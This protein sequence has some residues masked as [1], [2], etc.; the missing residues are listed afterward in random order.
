MYA[1]WLAN[2]SKLLGSYNFLLLAFPGILSWWAALSISHGRLPS[3]TTSKGCLIFN[4][5]VGGD[6]ELD[7]TTI[8]S[9]RSL[10]ALFARK[11]Q[12]RDTA[13]WDNISARYGSNPDVVVIP[14]CKNYV[15]VTHASGM[16]TLY[17]GTILKATGTGASIVALELFKS[18]PCLSCKTMPRVSCP[19]LSAMTLGALSDFPTFHGTRGQWSRPPS[20]AVRWLCNISISNVIFSDICVLGASL[21]SA[22]QRAYTIS[23]SNFDW[24]RTS[25]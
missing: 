19:S 6:N 23:R 22:F 8:I 20:C 1:W 3:H 24:A 4:F 25:T 17:W 21:N 15:N 9:S 10:I 12:Y 2:N 16:V 7:F 13:Y 5:Q 11:L 18:H 14:C